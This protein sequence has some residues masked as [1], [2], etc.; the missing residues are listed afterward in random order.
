LR[1]AVA[2]LRDDIGRAARI[3]LNDVHQPATIFPSWP[4]SAK[5]MHAGRRHQRCYSF[6]IHFPVGPTLEA[7]AQ[8]QFHARH[9]TDCEHFHACGHQQTNPADGSGQYARESA[10]LL[11]GLHF[12]GAARLLSGL[13]FCDPARIVSGLCFCDAARVLGGLHFCGVARDLG[14]LRFCDAARILSSVCFGAAMT[15]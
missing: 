3:F 7:K 8:F 11:G 4:S 6:S 9:G 1:R 2:A 15:R 5:A 14:G 13:C 12:C 10:C